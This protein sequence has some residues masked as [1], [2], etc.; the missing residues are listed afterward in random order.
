MNLILSTKKNRGLYRPLWVEVPITQFFINH[1]DH[2]VSTSCFGSTE[3]ELFHVDGWWHP[4]QGFSDC[5]LR[6]MCRS[7]TVRFQ[8]IEGAH[9]KPIVTSGI[10][11]KTLARL[12]ETYGTTEKVFYSKDVPVLMAIYYSTKR[13]DILK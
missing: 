3:N 6:A 7:N 12:N 1:I 8:I 5:K 11:I 10:N 2:L 13:C 9:R 4:R